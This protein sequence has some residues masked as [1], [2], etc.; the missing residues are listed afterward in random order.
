MPYSPS[1]DNAAAPLDAEYASS[2]AAEFRTL[3]TKLN[4]LFL[5]SNIVTAQNAIYS[6]KGFATGNIGGGSDI[7][8]GVLGA[9]QRTAGVGSTFGGYFSASQGDNVVSDA[10]KSCQGI[11]VEAFTGSVNSQCHTFCGANLNV[12]QRDPNGQDFVQALCLRFNDRTAAF[13]AGSVVGGLGANK[14]NN[15]ASAI[16]IQSQRRS[17]ATEHC[18]WSRGVKFEPYSLDSDNTIS[19]PVA[20]D[21]EG[22]ATSDSSSDPV[23]F[24]FAPGSLD[25][26]SPATNS[27]AV[28]MPTKV[29]GWIPVK[30]GGSVTLAIPL[31][32]IA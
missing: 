1:A 17:T 5:S 3:K 14:F 26:T 28:N 24:S 11:Y 31:H 20:I 7:F 19:V 13:D 27:G 9:A 12:V 25:L 16:S 2:A 18:G 32:S 29:A 4:L 15:N 6:T 8:F 21:F 30:V 23:A 10:G 22:I